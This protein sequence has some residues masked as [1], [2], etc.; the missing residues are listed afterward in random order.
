MTE[1]E[2]IDELNTSID[3]AKMCTKNLERKREVQGYETAI[4]ALK[5]IQQ[6]R[7]I[8][9]VEECRAAVEKQTA[10]RP[11]LKNGESGMF[12]DYTDG[13]G[14]YKVAKWQDWVCPVCGW[15]VGQRYNAHRNG[16]KPHPHDQRKSK[17]CN[18]CGQKLDWN[19]DTVADQEDTEARR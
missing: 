8:G 6:Y 18:E 10:K 1:N 2:A 13:H 15:F 12:V 5:E 3:L 17:Y 9:T 16:S 14:E 11:V 7:E 19:T 4:K